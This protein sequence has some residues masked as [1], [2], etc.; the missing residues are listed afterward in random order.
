MFSLK[1]R[2]LLKNTGSTARDYLAIERNSLAW[3]RTI[4]GFVVFGIAVECFSQLDISQIQN[5]S[6]IISD[7]VSRKHTIG[8]S[9]DRRTQEL[10]IGLLGTGSGVTTYRTARYFSNM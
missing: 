4:L 2:P 9:H 1:K 10:V 8:R 6:I 5:Q 3:L 7:A